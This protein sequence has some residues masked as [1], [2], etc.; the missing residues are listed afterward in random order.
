[1][2]V[3][4]CRLLDLWRAAYQRERVEAQNNG[5]KITILVALVAGLIIVEVGERLYEQVRKLVPGSLSYV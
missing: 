1:M 3:W 2:P 4:L 5:S